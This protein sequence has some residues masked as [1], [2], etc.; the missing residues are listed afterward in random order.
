MPCTNNHLNVWYW[1]NEHCTIIL[2]IV[3]C[4]LITRSNCELRGFPQLQQ[5]SFG[6]WICRHAPALFA[7]KR[8]Y[9][10]GKF[11]K[12]VQVQLI[13]SQ[14][15]SGLWYSFDNLNINFGA[16]RVFNEHFFTAIIL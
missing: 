3:S 6:T 7:R 13:K 2:C 1:I 14:L 11:F 15:I 5:K 16:E 8:N 9:Y 10:T 4:L 12:M